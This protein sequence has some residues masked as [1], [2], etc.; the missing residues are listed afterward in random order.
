MARSGYFLQALLYLLALHR[1]LDRT[2]PHYQPDQHLGGLRYLFLRGVDAQ[3][4]GQ[5]LWEDRPPLDLILEL[6]QRLGAAPCR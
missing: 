6:D 4:P 5:G 2:L 1:H 3:Q